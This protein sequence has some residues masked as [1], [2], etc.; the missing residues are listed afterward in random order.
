MLFQFYLLGKPYNA[1]LTKV[2]FMAVKDNLQEE[3]LSPTEAIEPL[4]FIFKYYLTALH[5]D[6]IL[7]DNVVRAN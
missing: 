2:C 6:F 5:H 1:W 7:K 4:K 3:H